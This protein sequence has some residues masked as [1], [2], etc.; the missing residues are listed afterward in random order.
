MQ[1]ITPHLW[2]DKEAKEAA[3][4]YTSIFPN[5]KIR[6][7]STLENTPSGAVDLAS[8]ELA[9]Q[10]F[11][12]ISAGPMFKFTPATSFVVAC[13]TK[14][15]V[16]AL[17]RELSKGGSVLMA[18]DQYPFSE[19]SGIT[20]VTTLIDFGSKEARDAA[21]ATGMTDGMEQSYQLLDGLLSQRV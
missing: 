21:V 15:E 7:I 13:E 8:I 10:E 12:L 16:D 5:S 3:K 1:K 18:L 11:R 14:E 17:W 19:N 9:G 6:S 4:F 2:F 20:R